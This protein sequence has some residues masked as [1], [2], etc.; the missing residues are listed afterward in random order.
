M[1]LTTV[2][3]G[4]TAAASAAPAASE[5]KKKKPPVQE[6]S[7]VPEKA[8]DGGVD[9]PPDESK[10][11]FSGLGSSGFGFDKGSSA[12]KLDSRIADSMS[13]SAGPRA[14]QVSDRLDSGAAL[15]HP[16]SSTGITG[17]PVS[18][19]VEAPGVDFESGVRERVIRLLQGV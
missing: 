11:L 10:G 13:A 7:P 6:A 18:R 4:A 9:A 15:L 17:Q 19:A 3:A 14:A 12:G 1:S 8:P 16:G 5:Y 2:P